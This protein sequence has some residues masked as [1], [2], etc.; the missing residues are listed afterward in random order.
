VDNLGDILGVPFKCKLAVVVEACLLRATGLK[1]CIAGV[2]RR[3]VVRDR[4]DVETR[5]IGTNETRT[6]QG[7]FPGGAPEWTRNRG[8][9]R[10][11]CFI[12]HETGL[13]GRLI[14]SVS[15]AETKHLDFQGFSRV[16]FQFRPSK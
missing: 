11:N 16:S 15:Q 2:W 10:H 6:F 13:E 12:S 3:L 4:E 8:K 1:L 9:T 14:V 5:K 7:L